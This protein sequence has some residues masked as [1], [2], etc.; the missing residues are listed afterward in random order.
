MPKPEPYEDVVPPI[1]SQSLA[2]IGRIQ[3]FFEIQ[4]GPHG[5]KGAI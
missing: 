1:C 4:S 5:K 2:E 3:K